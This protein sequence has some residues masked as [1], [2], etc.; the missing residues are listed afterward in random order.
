VFCEK[1]DESVTNSNYSDGNEIFIGNFRVDVKHFW[2]DQ[3][4]SEVSSA[5]THACSDLKYARENKVK[6]ANMSIGQKKFIVPQKY[7]NR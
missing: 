7:P 1:I 5:T 4:R 3:N 6:N 2:S